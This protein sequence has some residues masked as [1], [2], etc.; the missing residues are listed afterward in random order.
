MISLEVRRTLVKSPPELWAELSDPARLADHLRGLGEIRIVGTDPEQMV[1]WEAQDARGRVTIKPSAWGTRVTL[2]VLRETPEL[3]PHPEPQPEP[4]TPEHEPLVASEAEGEPESLVAPEPQAE[5]EPAVEPGLEERVEPEPAELPAP[6]PQLEPRRGFLARLFSWRKRNET[7]QDE[8]PEL[9]AQPAPDTAA[10]I[11][12]P[13]TAS[14][15]IERRPGEA[16][17][18]QQT[19]PGGDRPETTFGGA[20]DDAAVVSEEHETDEAGEQP[21]QVPSAEV[22]DISAELKTAE[23]VAAEQVKAMLTSMLDRLGAAHHRPFSRA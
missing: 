10:Q 8:R 18:P 23:E 19:P 3:E 5:P 2:S 7:M 6:E 16:P 1:E 11:P 20:R 14:A 13:E 9:T 15:S 4:Q 17:A 22:S 21:Q 12:P